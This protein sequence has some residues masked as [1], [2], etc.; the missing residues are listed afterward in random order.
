MPSGLIAVRCQ[1]NI[2]NLALDCLNR[3]NVTPRFRQQRR[4]LKRRHNECGKVIAVTVLRQ[5]SGLY[6]SVETE[7]NRP[8]YFAE[9]SD[10]SLTDNFTV[11]TCFDTKIAEEASPSGICLKEFDRRVEVGVQP[12]QWR[13]VIVAKRDIEQPYRAGKVL[14]DNLNTER[15]LSGEMVREAALR[16]ASS[17]Y[18]VSNARSVESAFMNEVEPNG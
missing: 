3:C 4:P 17:L 16:H 10:D 5:V 12:F 7:L 13:Q 1:Q 2:E 9:H 6:G 15:F 8:L 18:D 14:V 11:G